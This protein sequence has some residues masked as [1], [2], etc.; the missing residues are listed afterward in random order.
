[1]KFKLWSLQNLKSNDQK[2]NILLKPKVK[3]FS[4]FYYFNPT[5]FQ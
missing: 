1:M 4:G 5:R 2:N 3:D